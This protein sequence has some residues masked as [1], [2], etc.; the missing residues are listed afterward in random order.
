MSDFPFGLPDSPKPSLTSSREAASAAATFHKGHLRTFS[1][2]HNDNNILI[3]SAVRANKPP[4][5]G[6]TRARSRSVESGHLLTVTSKQTKTRQRKNVGA[7]RRTRQD[8]A[9]WK[10]RIGVHVE[11][12][13]FDLKKLLSDIYQTLPSKWELVDCYDVIRM[14]LPT[15]TSV[16]SFS[17]EDVPSGEGAYADGDGQIHASMPEVFVFGFGAVVFWN[18]SD[19][20]SEKS[21]IEQYLFPHKEVLGLKHNVECIESA[22]DE[23]GFCYGE[24][25]GWH[26]DVVQLRTRD[27]GE[28]LAVS[29]AF[30]KSANLS[31]YEW[32]LE[33]AIQ[34]N[35][36]IP[37][38]LAEHGQLHLNRKEINVEIGRLYLLN[39]AINLETNMLDTPEVT[40]FIAVHSLLL[41]SSNN[42]DF[43]N[44]NLFI[45]C[46]RN[47]GM[48]SLFAYV[49]YSTTIRLY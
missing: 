36:H 16:H 29:F 40:I 23:M 5:K 25:F 39:N 21:W 38:D 19:E 32:R 48:V 18:F 24:K 3:S 4:K 9:T 49:L 7:F 43:I 37:E 35:A 31:I 41:M 1:S 30:A 14:W 46:Y 20:A 28:K 42:F 8:Y 47:F 44:M 34:R 12:E 27:A 33:Q 2:N 26:R 10:G 15:D 22:C 17:E 11:Y 45:S 6:D 13:E